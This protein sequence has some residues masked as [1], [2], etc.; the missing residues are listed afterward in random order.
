MKLSIILF[1]D[2]DIERNAVNPVVAPTKGDP[3]QCSVALP[4]PRGPPT[5]GQPINGSGNALVVAET[6][7]GI[8]TSSS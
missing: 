4:T 8:W 2:S 7:T 3:I 1:V 5:R 6:M